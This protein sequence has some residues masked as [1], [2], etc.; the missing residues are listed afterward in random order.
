MALVPGS[1]IG[2]FEIVG[3]L[4]AGGM[5]EVFRA[6][7][8]R[9]G[10][11][12][13]IKAL[14]PAF[15]QDPERVARFERE[16]KLL[17]SLSHPNIGA[18][19]GLEEVEGH[20]Y[21]VLEF[22][23][24]ETLDQRLSRGPL[25][26][27][28]SLD[29]CR[30]IAAAVE[31]AH[32]SGVVHRDLKPGNVMLT[33]SGVV[34]VLDFGLA[35]A[36]DPSASSDMKLS[37]SPT[38]TYAMTGV[39]AILGTAAYMSP[40]QAR[41]KPVD[42]RTDIWS[43][44][45]VLYECLTG[46]RCFEGETVSDMIARILQGEPDWNALPAQT[47]NRV[48]E[49]MRR[50]LDKDAR[51]R[52]RDIGDARIELEEV[53]A[54]RTSGTTVSAAAAASRKRGTPP[55]VVAAVALASAAVAVFAWGSLHRVAPPALVQFEVPDA[56]GMVIDADG[57]NMAISPD[58][59][60][61]AFVA[62]DSARSMIW[63]RPMGSTASHALAGTE[64][65]LQPFWSPDSKNIAF[66]TDTKLK[67]VP[68]A[69]GEVEDICEVKRARGG[70]WSSKD[71][72]VYSPTSDGPLFAVPAGGGDS[73]QVTQVDST[74]GETGHRF[75]LFL[76]DHKHFLY[77]ALPPKEGHYEIYAG[78]VDGGKPTHVLQANSGAVY[79][80]PGVLLYRKSGNVVVQPFD[81]AALKIKGSP[82]SLR[83]N[84]T[85]TNR[86]GA[87][88]FSAS[89]NGTLAFRTFKL[90]LGT[91]VWY[92]LGEHQTG[93]VPMPPVAAYELDVAP[94]SRRAVLSR[95]IDDGQSE[96]WI[97]DLERGVSTRL[98]E[99]NGTLGSPRWSPDGSR[100]AY[101]AGKGGPQHFLIR[102]VTGSSPA[103]SLLE[104]DH[105]FKQ[106]EGW[107]P[108][109][110]T[111]V[112]SRQDPTTRWDLWTVS[113]DGDHTPHPLLVS[114]YSEQ[115][116]AVS[117]DGK[118]FSYSSDESGK[119]EVYVQAFPGGGSKYQVTNGGGTHSR[120]SPDAK[121]LG[122]FDPRQPRQLSIADVIPGAEF[123]LGPPRP[124]GR[125][126]EA[127]F[128]ASTTIDGQ[129]LLAIMPAGKSPIQS[130][131][132]VMNWPQAVQSR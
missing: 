103:I 6:K 19:H 105:A 110:H 117:P 128:V 45:C 59:R 97:Y 38:M 80:P 100:V 109:G 96:I 69:G 56:D 104:D 93:R 48:R 89:T 92:D 131:T 78:S 112:Y 46:R 106:F 61:L 114:P 127:A 14:P 66:F 120:W 42:K 125:V 57:V 113:V 37:A 81:P 94:D 13:A 65:A 55:L 29:V 123:R 95:I 22:V 102:S 87:A 9:L 2:N 72:I 116:I 115:G 108:D 60:T 111:L 51:H 49:L 12:V 63:L 40:E 91:L 15:A 54:Q 130:L 85:P 122:F 77:A 1:R 47:P 129:H 39:G 17:A 53:I 4:G 98:S 126:P 79:A 73:R 31:A 62:G 7:D 36:A 76:P 11:D 64:D 5:G 18:I 10:R 86:S 132:V 121:Q 68:A 118:W 84:S 50:C 124:Y 71:V 74:H 25:P 82:G 83:A 58:G 23:E 24:G 3:A 119:P 88:G 21:L 75:P 43:F 35:K 67:R 32:E 34:K 101:M 20:R 16:A 70:S 90:P 8:S 27:A 107:T 52:L 30:Q 26:L 28:D 41:G 99:E 44:G 33:P